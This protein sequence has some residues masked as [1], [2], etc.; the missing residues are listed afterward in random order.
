[1]GRRQE[2]FKQRKEYHK[3]PITQL[4]K[5]MGEMEKKRYEENDISVENDY[6]IISSVFLQRTKRDSSLVFHL[7]NFLGALVF[8]ISMSIFIIYK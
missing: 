4:Q 2:Y 5:L 1:M 3:I 8:S 7:R 6:R